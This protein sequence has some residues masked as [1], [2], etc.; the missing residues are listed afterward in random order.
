[1]GLGSKL[2]SRVEGLQKKNDCNAGESSKEIRC[3]GNMDGKEEKNCKWHIFSIGRANCKLME[4]LALSLRY[5]LF[6]GSNDDIEPETRGW[7]WRTW[8]YRGATVELIKKHRVDFVGLLEAHN[9]I[10]C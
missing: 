7:G 2:L 8:G 10:Y 1:M 3:T 5:A 4:L 9:G 6:E